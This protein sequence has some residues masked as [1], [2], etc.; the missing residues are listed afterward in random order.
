MDVLVSPFRERIDANV[1]PDEKSGET[2]TAI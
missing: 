1:S 2:A